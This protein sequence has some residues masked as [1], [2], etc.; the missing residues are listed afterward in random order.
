[1]NFQQRLADILARMREAKLEAIVA[2]HDGAHFIET[3]NPVSVLTGFKSIGPAA[4]ILRNDGSAT[5]I[6]A[7]AWDAERAG[8]ACPYTRVIVGAND[9][10][11]ALATELSKDTP[12]ATGLAG[13]RFLPS[14]I[15]E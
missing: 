4:A 9:M 13:L 10:A 3:P 6:V 11:E 5:L 8:E 2:V 15:A 1:M 14:V 12:A 7:P